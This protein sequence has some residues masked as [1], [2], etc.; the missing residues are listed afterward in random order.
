[1][2]KPSSLKADW[3]ANN[4]Q[5]YR[6]LITKLKKMAKILALP[7]Q[8][9]GRQQFDKGEVKYCPDGKNG[10][11]TID[12]EFAV[13]TPP[14]G[15]MYYNEWAEDHVP[16]EVEDYASA[17]QIQLYNTGECNIAF[18]GSRDPVTR[19]SSEGCDG[20]FLSK[21][22][23]DE[24]FVSIVK[25]LKQL[26]PFV[27]AV[28]DN[29]EIAGIPLDVTVQKARLMQAEADL[30]RSYEVRGLSADD[31]SADRLKG[32][33]KAHRSVMDIHEAA[34]DGRRAVQQ[35]AHKHITQLRI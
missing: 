17:I 21:L 4:N 1:M 13:H 9:F 29:P 12:I 11:S 6:E 3:S 33:V 31:I 10:R 30:K 25:R 23:A 15:L 34:E 5:I 27:K 22:S 20:L 2:T 28:F 32:L 35:V 26:S 14:H 24:A 8:E 18:S 7:T 16:Y 19:F